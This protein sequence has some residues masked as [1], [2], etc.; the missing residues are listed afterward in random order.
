MMAGDGG[1]SRRGLKSRVARFENLTSYRCYS[2]STVT[3]PGG[4]FCDLA[5]LVDVEPQLATN[6]TIGAGGS[7]LFQVPRTPHVFRFFLNQSAHGAA[8]NA[9]AARGTV[10]VK[11]GDIRSRDNL[12]MDPR[13]G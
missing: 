4:N 5:V 10:T 13:R 7:P 9:L 3:A 8:F 12:Q 11:I 1:T 2:F 6:A